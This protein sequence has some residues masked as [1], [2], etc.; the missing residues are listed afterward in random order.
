MCLQVL[1]SFGDETITV[2]SRKQ[3]Q[4]VKNH[5]RLE[6]EVSFVFNAETLQTATV[7]LSIVDLMF[8]KLCHDGKEK[9]KKHLI[10]N[11]LGS[12]ASEEVL[13][14]SETRNWVYN[15]KRKGGTLRGVSAPSSQS[16]LNNFMAEVEKDKRGGDDDSSGEDKKAASDDDEEGLSAAAAKK[17][18]ALEKA[19]DKK[20]AKERK[21]VAI[22]DHPDVSVASAPSTP[23][24][25][26]PAPTAATAGGTPKRRV[27]IADSPDRPSPTTHVDVWL[28]QSS[29]AASPSSCCIRIHH[30]ALSGVISAFSLLASGDIVCVLIVFPARSSEARGR[31]ARAPAPCPAG[32]PPGSHARSGGRR[33]QAC[34]S[35]AASSAEAT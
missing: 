5:Y 11:L 25:Q 19:A 28:L 26:P 2:R 6:W 30:I 33:R 4:C 32:I 18:A 16:L 35:R 34:R 1:I 7:A 22:Q 14:A 10:K 24:Q 9:G 29:D 23:V 20:P 21:R 27:Q 8:H 3:E 31:G 12:L 13:E 17:K 15:P